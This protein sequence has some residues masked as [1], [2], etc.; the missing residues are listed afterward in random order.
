MKTKLLSGCLSAGER[1]S[2]KYFYVNFL[3][4]FPTYFFPDNQNLSG[5]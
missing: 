1:G 5:N 3:A 2:Y 4:F